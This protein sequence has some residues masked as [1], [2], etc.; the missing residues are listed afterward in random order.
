[1]EKINWTAD[2]WP[3]FANDAG[4]DR[5]A[6]SMDYSDRFTTMA[7]V[8]RWRVN[9]PIDASVGNEGLLL[10]ASQDNDGIGSLLVQPIT[11][12][13][14]EVTARVAVKTTGDHTGAS[15]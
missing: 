7:P 13:D 11:S 2:G 10:A 15:L 5:D 12:I 8:W 14:Y 4:Y 1:L 3:V 9:Q 6:S